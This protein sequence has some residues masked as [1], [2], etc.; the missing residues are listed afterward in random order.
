MDNWWWIAAAAAG[1]VSALVALSTSV[2]SIRHKRSE[3]DTRKL[4]SLIDAINADIAELEALTRDTD[5]GLQGATSELS[6]LEE[7]LRRLRQESES[8]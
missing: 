7:L 8:R 3:L 4:K 1:I 5:K 6:R 2:Y